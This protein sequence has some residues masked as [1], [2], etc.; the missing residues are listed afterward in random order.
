MRS[1]SRSRL[2]HDRVIK[3]PSR[4]TQII[5]TVLSQCMYST[6][7]DAYPAFI[8]MKIL[9]YWRNQA[10][11]RPALPRNRKMSWLMGL[12]RPEVTRKHVAVQNGG[13]Q[14]LWNLQMNL[15]SMS[16]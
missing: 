13:C 16:R 12:E 7:A 11:P 14:A 5:I 4:K 8:R 2:D 15:I 6:H 9:R 3:V 1:K 10:I